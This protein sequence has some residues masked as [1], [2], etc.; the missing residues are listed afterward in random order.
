MRS[1]TRLK[2]KT[3]FV[4]ERTVARA[5]KALGVETDAEAVRLSLERVAEMEKFWR[6]MRRSRGKLAPG[7]LEES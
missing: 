2:R 7:S 3:F 4:D 1:S 6:F 5:R